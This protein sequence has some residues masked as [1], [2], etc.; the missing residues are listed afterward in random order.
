MVAGESSGDM[1]GADVA[2]ALMGRFPGCRIF[3][4]GGQKMRQAGVELEGD[5]RHTAA[6]GP[7]AAFGQLGSLLPPASVISGRKSSIGIGRTSVEV[8]SELISNIV[9]RK[10]S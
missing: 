10:R 4:L 8:R 1:Y 5:I 6:M 3:G 2:L 9:W 7:L